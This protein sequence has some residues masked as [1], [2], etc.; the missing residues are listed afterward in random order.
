ML[1]NALMSCST[2]SSVATLRANRRLVG[3]RTAL[4]AAFASL[5]PSVHAAALTWDTTIAADA[6]IT[7][8]NG[9]WTNGAGNWGNGTTSV[10]I[11]WNNATPDSATFA[12][13][14]G[15]YVV[16]LGGAISS[17]S[18]T[19]NASGYT[20]S[21]PSA[22]TITSTGNTNL[23]SGVTATIGS[24]ATIT[25]AAND[26]ITTT[27]GTGGT[28]N[29]GASG[30]TSTGAQYV[31][32]LTGSTGAR[33]T[34]INARTV[35]NVNF[36]GYFGQST[37]TV[38]NTLVNPNGTSIVIGNDANGGSLVVKAGGTI[39]NGNNQ[40]F[41]LGG[42]ATGSG[43]LTIDGGQVN[44]GTITT[45][46]LGA[47]P[48]QATYAGLRFGSG[49][50]TSGTR[51]TN[52]NGGTLTVGQIYASSATVG[53]SNNT[54]NFNG[55]TLQASISNP[56]FMASG[57]VTTANVRAGGA[58]IDTNSFNVTVGQA[59]VHEAA[60]GGTVDGGLT[61]SG[62]G[63]LTLTNTNTYTGATLVNGGTLSLGNTTGTINNSSGITIDGSGAKFL[64]TNT[65]TA[66]SPTVTLTQ[67]TLTGSGTVNTVNVGA[68]TGGI[69]SNNNGVAGAALTIGALTF[70]GAA[71]VNTFSGNTSAAIVTTGALSTTGAGSVTIN[72]TAASW[73]SATNY[74]LISFGSLTG[75]GFGA[76]T[77]GTV[78][79]ITS[80]QSA[81]LLNSGSAIQLLL[82]GD[83]PYWTGSGDGK[84]NLASTNNWTLLT[85]G[86][87]TT[88]LAADVTLFNDS[89]TGS[90]PLSVNVD[91]ANVAPASTTFNN[92]T[93]DY[94]LVGA[95]GISGGTLTKS[96][97]G[98]LT[99]GTANTYT[100]ATDIN[101]GAVTL[102]GNGTLGT[103][104]ALT[105]GGGKL[106]LGG[107]S[108]SV[109][110]VSVT[111]S[112]ASGDTIAN[113]NLTGTSY[114][115]SNASGDV[116]I[117][118]NLLANGAAGFAK[119]GNGNVTLSGANTYT[120]ATGINGGT[121]TISGSGT[122][123]TGSALTLGGGKL[124]LGGT[125]QSVGAV[126]V[127]TAAASGDTIGNGSLTGTS[128]AASNVATTATISANLL[129]N[130]A[131][132]FTKSGSGT[133]ILSGNNTYTG[134]T[135]VNAGVLNIQHANALGSTTGATSVVN[136]ATLQ[137]QGGVV[138]APETLNLL[139]NS[140][141]FVV[142]KNLS[143][144][145]EWSGTIASASVSALNSINIGSDS[146]V[147]TLSG[148]MSSSGAPF[149]FR[150]NGTISV[151]GQITG[152][153]GVASSSGDGIRTL[154]NN[155]NSYTGLT[156]VSGGTLTFSSIKNSDGTASALGA[157][158]NATNGT[159]AI[160][161]GNATGTIVYVGTGDTTNRVLNLA[162]TTGNVTIDQ[163]GA[164]GLLK[165]TSDLTATGSGD[166][167]LTLQ[168]S[169]AG[170][171]EIAGA[172][173]N[174]SGFTTSLTK[175]GTG[176]W[177]L[178]GNNTYTGTTTVSQGTLIVSG[179]IAS[180]V[181]TI[182][183]GAVLTF[184]GSSSAGNI[185]IGAGASFALGTA[186][187]ADAV[188]IN[189]GTFSGS[190]T[191][192]SLTFTGASVFGPG[193]SPGTVTIADGGTLTMS[194]ATV[195]NFEITSAAFT[196]GSYDLVTKTAGGASESVVFDGTLNLLFSGGP[197][198]VSATAVKIF[199]VDSYSGNFTSVVV[200]GLDTGLVATFNSSTGYVSIAAI[201]EPS[202][203]AALSG[204][205]MI[206][207]VLYRR[208][209]Q[210]KAKRAA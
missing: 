142:L 21:A 44:A 167:T 206:G 45:G 161:S 104:S 29:V 170:T 49:T 147:L 143:G 188:T 128:Y 34:T 75:T 184:T 157:P 116:G 8:G 71:T 113:G 61:K 107:T 65:T 174:S 200:S 89:A 5:A 79:G 10:G 98:N 25:K 17:G 31:T 22:Q 68:G 56:T 190:G 3:L 18:L 15:T 166:K 57:V 124:D 24:N 70:G 84:W 177:T 93:K 130:G 176:T 51:T 36:G 86:T 163:S 182:S 186:G 91:T 138:F 207:F 28:F 80:R 112:A 90:G 125:S 193:N 201:P 54:F 205:G 152:V 105:L 208:R 145:N 42:A 60:L 134:A 203:Y 96:G 77:L 14:A 197:Y 55:G 38:Y 122:L 198:S 141:S 58:K 133:V 120:G 156:T 99:I 7:A 114:A 41:I 1:P 160:G 199:D 178:S 139:S 169:T 20:L 81:S 204:V 101:G 194:S 187:T 149:A 131:A 23:A 196:A 192:G 72:P 13:T 172:I 140:A 52:L 165:F 63:T 67:G 33:T 94:S 150:G 109:G 83:T 6:T 95:F 39:T 132:G 97:T 181:T 164:S 153:T 111:T 48:V 137:L 12:G 46:L 189:D 2:S 171:G 19:F 40:A 146:G 127:T 82:T 78:G 100:G 118:A 37:A 185:T 69:I 110:A 35:V 126:S 66:V 119:T 135:A 74:N 159:I 191:V 30:G 59:L 73:A 85:A 123:G 27:S 117:S 168:G 50:M 183:P 103:G 11:N 210:Q 9:T 53:T 32:T 115:V 129:A 148:G 76:F 179:T 209:R 106:N 47:A 102:S 108:Q 16:T 144:N 88:F 62:A 155:A 121:V 195:S 202:A 175:N 4:L 162:G 64:Q 87:S 92:T 158:V 136:T 43:T 151:T 173:V 26:L 180:S 154:S